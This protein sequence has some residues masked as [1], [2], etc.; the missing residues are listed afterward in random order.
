MA[1][2]SVHV[3]APLNRWA[4]GEGRFHP[5]TPRMN[6]KS[7]VPCSNE[8]VWATAYRTENTRELGMVV[9]I[10]KPSSQEAEVGGLG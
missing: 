4:E 6:K 3:D 7:H 5:R 10:C 1:V 9:Y 2:G 8:H